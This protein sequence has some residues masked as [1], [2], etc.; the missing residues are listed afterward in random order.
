MV[1]AGCDCDSGCRGCTEKEVE[2]LRVR[3]LSKQK[4]LHPRC[5]MEVLTDILLL[6]PTEE[7]KDTPLCPSLHFDNEPFPTVAV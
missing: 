5:L 2:R 7:G 3:V 1:G 6:R 4:L